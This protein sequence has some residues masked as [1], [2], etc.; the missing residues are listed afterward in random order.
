MLLATVGVLA[1]A[2]VGWVWYPELF[3]ALQEPVVDVA[4][5]RGGEI[6]INFAGVATPLDMQIKVA[7][8]AGV[9]VSSPWWI[10]QLWG[11]VA[12]GLTR[13]ERWTAIAFVAVGVPLFVAGAVLAWRFMPV[14]VGLLAGFTPEDAV[15]LIDAH[16]YLGFVMR[17]TLAFGLAFLLPVVLVGLNLV[18]V[19]TA[20]DLLGAW[21]WAVLLAFVFSAVATP[22][23]D[24]ITMVALA[25]PI[26]LLYAAAVGVCALGDRRRARREPLDDGATS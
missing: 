16:M 22:T 10:L 25:V 4:A 24:A 3:A 15:N 18:G 7:L 12:P 17:M 6:A 19:L 1:G 5:A 23:G 8:F 20:R 13:R 11:F 9:I 2:V 14:A 26:C 21:R